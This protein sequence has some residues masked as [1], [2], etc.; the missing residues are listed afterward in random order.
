L[1]PR[2]AQPKHPKWVWAHDPEVYAYENWEKNIETMKAGVTFDESGI[3][4]NFPEGY[5]WE[6]WTIDYIMECKKNQVP[7]DLGPGN[8]D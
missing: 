4:P 2:L 6:P 3:P 7:V 8:W 5:K 1:N